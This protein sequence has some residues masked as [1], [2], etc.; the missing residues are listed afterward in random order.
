MKTYNIGVSVVLAMMLIFSACSRPSTHT[1]TI[2]TGR[3]GITVV[4]TIGD[5]TLSEPRVTD[6]NGNVTVTVSS[7]TP[8]TSV[9]TTQTS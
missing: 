4:V 2:S 5:R 7:D 6:S 9:G 3:P 8:C 1:C